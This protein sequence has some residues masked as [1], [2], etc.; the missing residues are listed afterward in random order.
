MDGKRLFGNLLL[1]MTAFIW[2]T[3]FV[4]SVKGL[5]ILPAYAFNTLRFLL[6]FLFIFFTALI[7]DFFRGKKNQGLCAS[8]AFPFT[9]W[10]KAL[11]AGFVCGFFLFAASAFQQV[12][13][14]NT[15]AGK[16]AFI[17]TLYIVIVP[18]LCLF[19]GTRI[20]RPVW[21]A[22]VLGVVG[23]Y[24]LSMT[25]SMTISKPDLLV[26]IGAFF[27]AGHI[28]SCDYFVQGCDPLKMSALQFAFACA[29]FA[30]FTFLFE[31]PSALKAWCDAFPAAFFA[32][33]IA[34][35]VGFTFQI[36]AQRYT[37]PTV[38]ALI[39]SLESVF[40]ALAGYLFLAETLS[41]RELLGCAL[42]LAAI[43]LT[44]I[45]A[46]MFLRRRKTEGRSLL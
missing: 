45:P 18:F 16:A 25:E 19:L 1:S 12:G 34:C 44:Q 29:F 39:L 31:S 24:L 4:A 36:V 23:L 8:T 35:G 17:T 33:L 21:F 9:A 27:W 32:G 20:P 40:A 7:V 43:L 15:Q 41:R 5:R 46:D 22:V 37:S 14:Q 30:L 2:G 10:K 3:S 28:M 11:S 38:T 13:L 6:A 26:L 42:I